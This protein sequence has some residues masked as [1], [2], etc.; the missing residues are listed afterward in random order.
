MAAGLQRGLGEEVLSPLHPQQRP[1]GPSQLSGQQDPARSSPGCPRCPLTSG[2]SPTTSPTLVPPYDSLGPRTSRKVSVFISLQGVSTIRAA[3]RT[4]SVAF[5]KHWGEEIRG[6]TGDLGPRR[7]S[8]PSLSI[9]PGTKGIGSTCHCG[10]VSGLLTGHRGAG[11][12]ETRATVPVTHPAIYGEF[13]TAPYLTSRL[14]KDPS[15]WHPHLL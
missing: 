12:G 14:H 15:A 8:C 9:P 4:P 7:K 10:E 6:I 5:V 13:N 2:G 11:Q 3:S 1:G